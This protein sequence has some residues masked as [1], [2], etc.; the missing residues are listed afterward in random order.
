MKRARH[1]VH[2]ALS[3][4]ARGVGAPRRPRDRQPKLTR[5]HGCVRAVARSRSARAASTGAR[6]IKTKSRY[7]WNERTSVDVASR[8]IDRNQPISIGGWRRASRA[9]SASVSRPFLAR[10]RV[11]VGVERRAPTTR[12]LWTMEILRMTIGEVTASGASTDCDKT[13]LRWQT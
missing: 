13:R 12:C 10:R 7:E 3:P 6:R 2:D 9:S 4:G 8:D 1:L 11:G 5:A